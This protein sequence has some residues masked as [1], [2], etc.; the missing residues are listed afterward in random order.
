MT[1]SPHFD[2]P[3]RTARL[4]DGRRQAWREAG[5]AGAPAWV[6]LHG[7]SSGAGSWTAVAAHLVAAGQRVLAWDAPGYGDS[8]PLAALQPRGA[9]LAAAIGAWLVAAEVPRCWL[10]GH[11][12]G[13]IAAVAF[14]VDAARRGDGAS[15][16]LGLSL[17]SPAAG[18]GRRPDPAAQVRRQRLDDLEHLGIA[19]LAARLP[20]RLTAPQ[21]NAAAREAVQAQALRMTPAGYRAAVELLCGE[22]LLALAGPGPAPRLPVP[23][24]VHVGADDAVTPP[25]ACEAVAAALGVP[26]SRWPGAGHASPIETPAAVA[27][28]LLQD[29]HQTTLSRE[30]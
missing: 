17:C 8:E 28:T 24:Y 14:A 6:L 29:R 7:I 9:D 5:P 10:V 15:R 21:A 26:C 1:A 25:A 11:S 3:L 16:V 4:A 19:G 18:Y 20:Q 27:Q 12:L 2:F 23:V 13:A 30:A 22:D